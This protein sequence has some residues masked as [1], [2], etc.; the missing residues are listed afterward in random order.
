MMIK[1][2]MINDKCKYYYYRLKVN[3]K[4]RHDLCHGHKK[5]SGALK[6]FRKPLYHKQE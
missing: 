4:K 6:Y 2:T 3:V 5:F 1:Y